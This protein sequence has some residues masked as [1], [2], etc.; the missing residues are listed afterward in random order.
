MMCTFP[1]TSLILALCAS[2]SQSLDVCVS[3]AISEQKV[4]KISFD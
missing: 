3:L 1:P 2:L 4:N